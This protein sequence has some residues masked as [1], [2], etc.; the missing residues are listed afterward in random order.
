MQAIITGGD[1]PYVKAGTYSVAFVGYRTA[2]M[3]AKAPKL[4]LKFKITDF[5]DYFETE[6]SRWYNVQRIGKQGANGTFKVGRNSAFIRE[7]ARLFLQQI[8]KLLDR[9]PMTAFDNCIMKA[10]VRLV[11]KD[12]AQRE[13]AEPLQ[14]SVISELVSINSP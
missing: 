7:Y 14:Y 4:E 9:V 8:T 11:T 3:F 12:G 6:I 2:I 10:K 13:L 5:G 1:L